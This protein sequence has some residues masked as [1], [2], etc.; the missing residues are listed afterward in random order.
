MGSEFI[1]MFDIIYTQNSLAASHP[2]NRFEGEGLD[3]K[4]YQNRILLHN[5]VGEQSHYGKDSGH[6]SLKY[7]KNRTSPCA[8]P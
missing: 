6:K 1:S 8:P 3:K 2:R 5:M 4:A 7:N